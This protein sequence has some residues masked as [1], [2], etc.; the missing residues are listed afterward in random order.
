MAPGTYWWTVSDDAGGRAATNTN[1][2]DALGEACFSEGRE[3][4]ARTKEKSK[5]MPIDARQSG[6]GITKHQDRRAGLGEASR[7]ALVLSIQRRS[8]KQWRMA[9][10]RI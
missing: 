5:E 10:I 6:L 7:A 4:R 1:M 9:E 3:S 2:R 8:D